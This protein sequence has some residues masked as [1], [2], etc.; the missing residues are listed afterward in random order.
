MNNKVNNEQVNEDD[1]DSAR[2]NDSEKTPEGEKEEIL[3]GFSSF[4]DFVKTGFT[5]LKAGIKAANSLPTG[6]NFTYYSCFPTFR[7]IRHEEI[8]KLLTSMQCIVECTGA[9]GSMKRG[10]QEEKFELLTEA[11]DLLLDRATACMDKE[12]GVS[13][14][15]NVQLITTQTKQTNYGSWNTSVIQST[16]SNPQEPLSSAQGIRLLAAKNIH[17]PQLSFKDKIDNS[18]KPWEP[19]IK[20]KPNALKPLSIHLIDTE[21]GLAYSHPYEWELDKLTYQDHQ[22]TP[23]TPIKYRPLS[24]TPLIVIEKPQ[25]L[26][27]LLNDLRNYEEISVDLEHHSYRTFQGITC[28]MQI[29]TRDT[30]YLIDTLSLRSDLHALNE[31]FTKPSVLK[32]FHGADSDIQWLQRDLSLYIVNMFDT[33]QAAK[34]L[35]LPYLSLA[36]LLKTH[37]NIDPNKHFQLADWRIRPLPEELMKYARED[38]HYLLYIKDILTNALIEAA[39]G[40]ANILR[41]VYDRSNEICKRIYRKPVCLEDSHMSIYRKSQKMFNNRQLHALKEL[42]SWRDETARQEDDSYGYVLPNHMLLNIAETLPREMQGILAC[43]NPIP[44]LVRQNLLKLHKLILRAREQPLIKPVLLEQDMRQRLAQRHQVETDVWMLSPHDMSNNEVQAN[45]PCLLDANGVRSFGETDLEARPKVT[46]FE[47]EERLGDG[48][49]GERL[50]RTKTLFVSPFERY[51]RVLPMVAAQEARD[52]AR[53]EREREERAAA[54]KAQNEET[55]QSI[56]RVRQHFLEVTRDHREDFDG[57]REQ[58]EREPLSN[59]PRGKKRKRES[60]VDDDVESV[61]K[62]FDVSTPKPARDSTLADTFKGRRI[63]NEEDEVDSRMDDK[64]KPEGRVLKSVRVYSGSA[65][66][67]KVQKLKNRKELTQKGML[68]NPNF[69]YKAVDFSSFQGG[70]KNDLAKTTVF[71]QK[72]FKDKITKGKKKKKQKLGI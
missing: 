15:P 55:Q 68:P 42:Y 22:L 39:N 66:K 63:Q 70:S 11:N 12:A 4:D 49:L 37:C 10:D 1:D 20:D 23:R 58:E 3:P 43:C 13:K 30:D 28:L 25:D 18:A 35:N 19:R 60:E 36:Y 7:N 38:T 27:I 8:K 29:S 33:H 45:L 67:T 62:K 14:E 59:M 71:Q 5:V 51:K 56:D 21:E 61:N 24:E 46:I 54:E 69:D 65:D 32:V 26:K 52:L 41:A 31:I 44:P 34:H 53:E 40:Q 17:R 16:S 57:G 2:E 9:S 47:D 72:Q 50:R 48:G 6:E 64:R